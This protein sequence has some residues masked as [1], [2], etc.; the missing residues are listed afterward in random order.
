[1]GFSLDFNDVYGNGSIA[2]GEYEVVI[3]QCNENATP[4]G[5][6]YIQFDLIIRN[7]VEQTYKNCHIFHKIWKAKATGK[8][9][10]KSL[11]TIGKAFKLEKDKTYAS[12]EELLQDFVLKTVRVIVKN[13][14]SDY[15]GKTYPNVTG[16][17]FS[18]ITGPLQ[19]QFKEKSDAQTFSEMKQSGVPIKD[20]DLPF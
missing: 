9:N 6:E 11:N 18:N 10:M 20:Q 12:F 14:L 13:E 1:M 19:H 5:A 4:G 15:D 3:S 16:W 8:Y 2:D 7:D 17:G